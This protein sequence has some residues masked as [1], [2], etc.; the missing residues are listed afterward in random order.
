MSIAYRR[1]LS[2]SA[3]KVQL[4]ARMAVAKSYHHSMIYQTQALFSDE[5]QLYHEERA[6]LE[7][8]CENNISIKVHDLNEIGFWQCRCQREIFDTWSVIRPNLTDLRL[9]LVYDSNKTRICVQDKT[10]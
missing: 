9:R 10:H 1:H 8:K 6:G 5:Q 2:D 3:K 7:L 4:L